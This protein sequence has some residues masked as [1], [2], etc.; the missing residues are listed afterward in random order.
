MRRKESAVCQSKG[1]LEAFPTTKIPELKPSRLSSDSYKV[2]ENREF[3]A[4]Y[5][6]K[7]EG[8]YMPAWA[9]LAKGL[10]AKEVNDGKERLNR[11]GVSQKRRKTDSIR[12]LESK[13]RRV[14]FLGGRSFHSAN[15]QRKHDNVRGQRKERM[16]TVIELLTNSDEK[17]DE[18]N[19]S[20]D[21]KR[22]EQPVSSDDEKK[23]Q[24]I[25]GS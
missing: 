15:Q 24:L 16:S 10:S 5:K 18:I 9:A 25:K 11:Q 8:V 7:S 17:N 4:G 6:Q 22:E 21:K 13:E 1:L 12:Y 2:R 3:S 23:S 20:T 14:I 19:T